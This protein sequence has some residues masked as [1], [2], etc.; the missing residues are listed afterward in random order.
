MPE[1]TLPSVHNRLKALE[2]QNSVLRHII[3]SLS[4]GTDSGKG[5]ISALM[6][7]MDGAGHF[8]TLRDITLHTSMVSRQWT[9][10]ELDDPQMAALRGGCWVIDELGNAGSLWGGSYAM[11][12]GKHKYVAKWGY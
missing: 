4:R 8:G 10:A 12:D 11:S 7:F 6:P 1:I 2:Y 9:D 5:A 3:M